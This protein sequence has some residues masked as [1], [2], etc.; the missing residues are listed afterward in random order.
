[1]RQL[2]NAGRQGSGKKGREGG[3][4][5]ERKIKTSI[6]LFLRSMDLERYLEGNISV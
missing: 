1:M 2:G 6:L 4:E 3:K 5:E